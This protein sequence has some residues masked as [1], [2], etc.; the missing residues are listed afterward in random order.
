VDLAS[1]H[2]LRVYADVPQDLAT[3]VKDGDPA[4]VTVT[5]YPGRTFDG[6]VTRHPEA[7]AQD[8]RTMRVEVDL[9]NKD[10][11][12]YPGMYATLRL[13]VSSSDK[14]VQVPDDSL[15]FRDG[16]TYVPLVQHGRIHLAKVILGNDD[17][18]SVAIASGIPDG[19]LIAVNVGNGAEDG[20]QVQP[21]TEDGLGI[22][23]SNR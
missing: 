1:L 7:L 13:S 21:V 22:E 2:P 14:A 10:S 6:T 3:F 5:Q 19:A 4:S 11:A 20:D 16:A 12:L 17:G 9:P 8:T 18:K 15:V 23:G